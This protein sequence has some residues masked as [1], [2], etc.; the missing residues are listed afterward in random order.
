MKVVINVLRNTGS[1]K[2]SS[3]LYLYLQRWWMGKDDIELYWARG[4]Q[5][6]WKTGGRAS[7]GHSGHGSQERGALMVC[8]GF[9]GN[10]KL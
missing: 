10:Q 3:V 4:E 2:I 1:V 9:Y 8:G 7:P 6:P 5:Y